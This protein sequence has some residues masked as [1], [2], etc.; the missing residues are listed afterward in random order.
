MRKEVL[1]ILVEQ[2]ENRITVVL[3]YML[4]FGFGLITNCFHTLKLESIYSS[5]FSTNYV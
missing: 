5:G 4:H 3:W 2:K 1:N